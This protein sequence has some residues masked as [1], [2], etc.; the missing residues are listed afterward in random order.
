[1]VIGFTIAA[2]TGIF[3]AGLSRQM[4]ES[5]IKQNRLYG[6]DLLGAGTGAIVFPLVIIPITGMLFGA[7]IITLSSLVVWL[8]LLITARMKKT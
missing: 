1:L 6:Y 8:I 3:F 7:I 4:V 2:A 5:K